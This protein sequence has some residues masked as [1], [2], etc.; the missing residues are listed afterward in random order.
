MNVERVRNKESIN[1]HRPGTRLPF[2]WANIWSKL[3]S[4]WKSTISGCRV[5][6]GRVALFRKICKDRTRSQWCERVITVTFSLL[7]LS[8][9]LSLLFFP[10]FSPIEYIFG[11]P[12]NSS[13]GPIRTFSRPSEKLW[14][15]IVTGGPPGTGPVG[16]KNRWT[17]WTL[18]PHRPRG[19]F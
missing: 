18:N 16:M 7:S 15:P 6:G 17:H 10:F 3:T 5:R 12:R 14:S 4:K 9:S 2:C 1:G 19:I 13:T 8:L 11:A